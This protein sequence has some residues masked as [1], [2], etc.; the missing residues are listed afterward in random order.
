MSI[1]VTS[2]IHGM[3]GKFI[4][5]LETINIG[6]DDTLYVLGDMVDRGPHPVRVIQKIMS[7]K[8]VKTILGNHDSGA[9]GTL[10][11]LAANESIEGCSVTEREF[12][13][14]SHQEKTAV[15]DFLSGLPLYY[16]ITVNDK[17]YIL[18]H[19]GLGN[20]APCKA[21][22]E[23][24]VD[25]LVWTRPDY[26]RP[27]YDDVTVVCGHT[28]TQL[29]EENDRPGYIMRKNNYIAVDCGACF[30]GGRLAAI[31]LDTGEEFYV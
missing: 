19:G 12:Q 14:L 25:E 15:I 5:M 6:E 17:R 31:C 16:D 29:I 3:Y 23:Y 8:N 2:D 21:M 4:K 13:T 1:Y 7:M 10:R 27:Y 28:P 24:S 11:F 30:K 20:F 22:D 18:V 26:S 9:L